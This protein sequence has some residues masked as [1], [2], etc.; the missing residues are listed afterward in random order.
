MDLNNPIP[1]E[2][3]GYVTQSA[4]NLEV[5]PSVLYDTVTY[6]DN[7][8]TSLSFFT[9]ARGN[10]LDLGNMKQAGMLSNPQSFLI[11][12]IRV[13]MKYTDVV[14][15][16]VASQLWNDLILLTNTGVLKLTI[17][18]KKYGPWPL[19]MF[20][21]GS[22]V[23]GM[24]AGANSN[25]MGYAQLSGPM[26]SVSP[27]LMIAPLCNFD[28]ELAWPSGAVDLTGNATLEVMFDGQ[29]ARAVQ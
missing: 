28:V 13:F 6:V 22:S 15:T 18:E 5:V 9:T 24:L 14:G 11:Q 10:L 7:T 4:L 2:W 27:Y 26:Y 21:S 23:N 16:T 8:S 12:A 17:G 20:P 19:W 29:L 3:T 25:F 1:Q